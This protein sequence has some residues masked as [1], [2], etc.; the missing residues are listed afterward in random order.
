MANMKV[1]THDLKQSPSPI[2]NGIVVMAEIVGTIA[3]VLA[4]S[5]L[6]LKTLR[7]I[8]RVHNPSKEIEEFQV[9]TKGRGVRNVT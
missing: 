4:L 3:A 5:E 8:R 2:H 1:Y 6:S 9:R 7:T